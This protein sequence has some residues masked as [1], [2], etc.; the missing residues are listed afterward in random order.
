MTY[1]IA[2]GQNNAAGLTAL[3]PQPASDGLLDAKTVYAV[4]R[5]IYGDGLF[6]IWRYTMLSETEY[7][8]LLTQT[9]LTS[10][11]YAEVTVK[12]NAGGNRAIW[13]NYN[14]IIQRAVN[15]RYRRGFYRD[16]EFTV[17]LLEAL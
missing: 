7:A 13:S 5:A 11:R 12:T 4:S 15:P 9:G 2:A 14:A 1:Q 10:V 17:Q 6:T 8:S 3:T 16:V